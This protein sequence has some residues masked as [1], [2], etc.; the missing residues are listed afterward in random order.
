MADRGP[1]SRAAVFGFLHFLF[2]SVT[3][4]DFC[5]VA[6]SQKQREKFKDFHTLFLLVVFNLVNDLKHIL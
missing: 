4:G 3:K 5:L 1:G 2:L 6:V